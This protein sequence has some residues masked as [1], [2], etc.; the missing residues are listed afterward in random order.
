MCGPEN[1][2]PDRIQRSRAAGWRCPPNT[3]YVGRPTRF[4][5]PFIGL[6][7]AQYFRRWLEGNMRADEFEFRRD[8]TVNAEFSDR[9]ELLQLEIPKLRGQ[10]LACWCGPHAAC[11]ADVLLEIANAK[12]QG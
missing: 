1:K 5:N 9:V 10:N 3:R 11:H 6:H 2:V 7:A 4:G 8:K 12:E